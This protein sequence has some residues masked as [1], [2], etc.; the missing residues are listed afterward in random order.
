MKSV[1]QYILESSNKINH[2]VLSGNGGQFELN[3]NYLHY[4]N[5]VIIYP[6]PTNN[7]YEIDEIYIKAADRN[8]GIGTKL[9]NAF[10]E[11]A[12]SNNK[13]IVLY[14]SPFN[15]EMTIDDL[16]KFYNKFGFEQDN[17]TTDKQC[18]ILKIHN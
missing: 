4:F 1:K 8:L 10:I 14:A 16:I 7:A 6:E 18:L 13:D 17:R 11:F 9:L 12:K 3:G 2:K 5:D 15:N